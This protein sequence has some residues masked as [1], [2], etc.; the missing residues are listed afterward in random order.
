MSAKGGEFV[1]KRNSDA[2]PSSFVGVDIGGT[3]IAA[4]LVTLGSQPVLSNQTK[5]PTPATEGAEAVVGAVITLVRKVLGEAGVSPL[6]VAI[7]SAGVVDPVSGTIVSATDLISGWAGTALAQQVSEAVGLPVYVLGDVQAHG[8]GEHV[9]GAGDGYA[10]S[11]LIGIGTGVGGAVVE[12]DSVRFGANGAA[13]H[14]GHI[15]A[16]RAV[17]IP[18]SCGTSGHIEGIA[19]GPSI[20][21][22]YGKATGQERDA[23]TVDDLAE[24]GEEGA[25]TVVTEAGLATGETLGA[26]ANVWDPDVII[27]SGS[28]ANSGRVWWDAVETGFNTEALKAVSATQI[29]RGTLGGGAPLIGAAH[30]AS[31]QLEIGE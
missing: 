5:L 22:A 1:M 12:G 27:V 23:K 6:A 13:G 20:T 4:A 28:V 15:P 11:L 29:K 30:W 31:K 24:A 10:S 19:S 21:R 7:A 16:H 14:L 26:L 8:L 3:K 9:Y 18:C 17:G 25:V 2:G